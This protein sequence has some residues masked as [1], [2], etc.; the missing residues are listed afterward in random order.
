MIEYPTL[1]SSADSPPAADDVTR[2][3]CG[4]CEARNRAVAIAEV[5]KFAL[6][7]AVDARGRRACAPGRA[8]SARSCWS[9]TRT[10]VARAQAVDEL[11]GARDRLPAAVDDAVHVGDHAEAGH[12]PPGLCVVRGS[13]H[14]AEGDDHLDE[15][16]LDDRVDGVE[17]GV[18]LRDALVG[19]AAVGER[20]QAGVADEPRRGRRCG[21]GSCPSGPSATS[22]MNNVRFGFM[23]S[24]VVLWQRSGGSLRRSP[25]RWPRW[26][27]CWTSGR[28]GC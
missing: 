28:V 3:P 20:E 26:L 19:G 5:M 27:R 11:L 8:A 14:A 22:P 10:G 12:A 13:R 6:G 21:R 18:A 7:Q 9:G 4:F 16:D 2:V 1:Y 23:I 15:Q 24:S 17:R 25:G